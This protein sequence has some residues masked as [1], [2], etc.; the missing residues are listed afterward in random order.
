MRK[1]ELKLG[2]TVGGIPE[3]HTLVEMNK[4]NPVIKQKQSAREAKE[5][6]KNLNKEMKEREIRQK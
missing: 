3:V 5:F 4:M 1:I 2:I 6:V